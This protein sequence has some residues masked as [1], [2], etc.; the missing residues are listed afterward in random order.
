M[1][2]WTFITNYGLVLA[3]I[4]KHPRSTAREIAS[5]ANITE[6]T[7]HKIIADLEA[8]GYVERQRVGRN[9][10][11]RINPDLGLRH[12]LAQD[13]VIGDL[14]QVLGWKR[15]RRKLSSG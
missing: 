1:P 7:T 13:A 6:R 12:E 4:A 3:H 15:R 10:V 9:N 14:L 11:Y 5:V 8:E 2:E